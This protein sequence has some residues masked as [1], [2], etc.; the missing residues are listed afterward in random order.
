MPRK[1][2]MFAIILSAIFCFNSCLPA[3]ITVNNNIVSQE[4]KV[5]SYNDIFEE[6][7]GSITEVQCMSPRTVF[8]ISLAAAMGVDIPQDIARTLKISHGS[9]FIVDETGW[10]VTNEHVVNLDWQCKVELADGEEY[11][12]EAMAVDEGNDIALLK[13]KDVNK[14]LPALK[15]S[16]TEPKTGDIILNVGRAYG[17]NM[18]FK[19]GIV[20]HPWRRV[21]PDEFNMQMTMPINRGESGSPVLNLK[22]EVVGIVRAY[23][24]TRNLVA[25]AVPL[26]IAKKS[27]QEMKKILES[28]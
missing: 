19:T 28:D 5:A 2:T 3:S 9:G 25:L 7:K 6:V 8:I 11:F 24:P 18:S 21:G 1:I 26:S 16:E 17:F 27:V 4:E 10:V 22:G 14:M 20:S 12:V 15:F 13:L 23:Y